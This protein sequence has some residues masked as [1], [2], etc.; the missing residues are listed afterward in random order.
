[1]AVPVRIGADE[2][3]HPVIRSLAYACAALVTTAPMVPFTIYCVGSVGINF[4]TRNCL[5]KE[6]IPEVFRDDH[7]LQIATLV[8]TIAVT[9]LI[10]PLVGISGV[11]LAGYSFAH[12]ADH[13]VQIEVAR[14][15][16]EI[17]IRALLAR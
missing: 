5:P 3:A 15:V 9:L 12:I 13:L 10:G 11:M 16:S 7:D 2:L 14:M 17:A 1:M 6:V 4:L 8:A